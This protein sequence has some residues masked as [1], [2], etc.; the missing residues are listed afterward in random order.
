MNDEIFKMIKPSIWCNLTI[1]QVINFNKKL[2]KETLYCENCLKYNILCFINNHP[3][4][5]NYFN[6]YPFVTKYH[7]EEYYD[8]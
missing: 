8:N 7:F 4:T 1:D 3:K 2:E 5:I 6:S